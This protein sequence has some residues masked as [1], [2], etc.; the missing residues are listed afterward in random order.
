MM[1]FV[2]ISSLSVVSKTR[3][4]HTPV[5]VL[6]TAVNYNANYLADFHGRGNFLGLTFF[7]FTR[8]TK[9]N[10]TYLS[11]IDEFNFGYFY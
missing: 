11:F 9:V 5:T 6:F 1:L 7:R 8:S 4:L 2:R 3:L 10:L